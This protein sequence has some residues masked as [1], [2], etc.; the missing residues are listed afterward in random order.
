MNIKDIPEEIM[1]QILKE[2]AEDLFEE[3]QQIERIEGK[4]TLKDVMD[5]LQI[6]QQ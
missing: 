6:N 5:I 4:I 1:E 2:Y 3:F